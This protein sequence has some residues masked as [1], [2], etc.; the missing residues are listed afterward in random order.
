MYILKQSKITPSLLEKIK[1]KQSII[2][3]KNKIVK[4]EIL[5][6]MSHLSQT[7]DKTWAVNHQLKK[8]VQ[9]NS[10]VNER[11]GNRSG[12]SNREEKQ[13]IFKND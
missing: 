13:V 7:R 8:I 10:Q 12:S 11:K 3:Q 6:L 2:L 1:G 5:F 4:G 9:R